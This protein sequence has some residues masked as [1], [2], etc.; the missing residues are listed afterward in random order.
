MIDALD[1]AG[2]DEIAQQCASRPALAKRCRHL[3]RH[4]ALAL[5]HD[6][7]HNDVAGK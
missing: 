6:P 4:G 3:R 5:K 2:V 1:A 7:P